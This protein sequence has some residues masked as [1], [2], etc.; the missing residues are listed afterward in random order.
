MVRLNKL[1]IVIYVVMLKR[2]QN[3]HLG[4]NISTSGLSNKFK[5]CCRQ[6]RNVNTIKNLNDARQTI[7]L[8]ERKKT[9]FLYLHF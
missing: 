6:T 2:R 3:I 9:E 8:Q 4:G 5:N 7:G 1:Q